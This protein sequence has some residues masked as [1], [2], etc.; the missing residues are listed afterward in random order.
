MKQLIQGAVIADPR[1][2]HHGKKRDLLIARGRIEEVAAK[3]T[4][5]PKHVVREKGLH[6]SPGWVDMAAQ[7]CD[8]G[9]EWKEDLH[10]GLDA[11]AAGGSPAGGMPPPPRSRQA[12][13]EYALRKA[14]G[15]R[16]Q[17]LVAGTLSAD[18]NGRQLLRWPICTCRSCGLYRLQTAGQPHELMTRALDYARGFNGLILSFH[19]R[20][21][22]SK[23]VM[24]EGPM[25]VSL[26]LQGL[27]SLRKSFAS[28]AIWICSA[29]PG[30]ACMCCW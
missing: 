24:H 29:T 11:A 27:P 7:F 30:D 14:Q 2:P 12:A 8:P 6:V 20:R 21:W 22:A 5:V 9:E 16:T 19:G 4:D 25:S 15:H 17:L 28:R 13:V 10:T 1:S 18:R 23:G 26:G 3:I